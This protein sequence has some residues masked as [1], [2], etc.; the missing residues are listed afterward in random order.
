MVWDLRSQILIRITT[1]WYKQ[2]T[3]MDAWIYIYIYILKIYFTLSVVNY[4]Y[5]T[6]CL[7]AFVFYVWHAINLRVKYAGF[8][9]FFRL[10]C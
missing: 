6:I 7:F 5:S 3:I 1:Y 2:A 4:K 8:A 10:L 9:I